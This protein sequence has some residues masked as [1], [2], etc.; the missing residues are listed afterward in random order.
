MK[1]TSRCDVFRAWTFGVFAPAQRASM[2]RQGF[3]LAGVAQQQWGIR[4]LVKKTSRCDV[5]RAWTFGVFAPAQ[6]ASMERQGFGLAK[7]TQPR[8]IRYSQRKNQIIIRYGD[9]MICKQ[10]IG[11]FFGYL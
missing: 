9:E 4:K 10:R 6:R 11:H 2:E 8:W 5:F 7:S 3:G 1:K